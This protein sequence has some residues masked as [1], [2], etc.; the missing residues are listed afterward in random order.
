M[1]HYVLHALCDVGVW[2]HPVL[3]SV[4]VMVYSVENVYNA[5]EEMCIYSR[6]FTSI[7]DFGRSLC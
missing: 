2:F 6:D 4:T 5:L 7:T 3:I 1:L